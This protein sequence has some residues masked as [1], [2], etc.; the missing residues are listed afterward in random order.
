MKKILSLILVLTSLFGV[1]SLTSCSVDPSKDWEN[2]KEEGVFVVGCTKFEPMN[3]YENKKLVGFDTEYAQAVAKYLGVKVEFQMIDWDTK[4]LEL[5]GGKIDCIWNGFTLNSDDDGV[6][7][8]KKVDFTTGYATNY[9]C[10][11]MKKGAAFTSVEELEGKKCAVEGGSAGESY[12]TELKADI[13]AKTT[14]QIKAFTE[15][16]SGSVDFIV[17]DVLLALRTCGEG[18]FADVEIKF[19]NKDKIELYGIGCRKGSNFDK[20][21]EEATIALLN[22]GKNGEPS[23]LEKLAAKYGVPLS[24]EILALKT[25]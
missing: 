14:S 8:T 22:D 23:T 25:K 5:E 19:E 7:R 16:K 24:A 20:K 11:V 12:A 4:Y 15:L 6:A 9:Q 17:V 21:L 3:Y 1:L 13:A 10:I 18:D 2:I